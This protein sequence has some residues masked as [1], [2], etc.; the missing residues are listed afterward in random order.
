MSYYAQSGGSVTAKDET[1]YKNMTTIIDNDDNLQFETFPDDEDLTI[2]LE[3]HGN[4]HDELVYAF[5]RSIAPFIKAGNIEYTGED[6]TQWRFRFD[7]NKNEWIEENGST[8]YDMNGFS[9]DELI[10]ELK[11]R[12]YTITKST[13][14]KSE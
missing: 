1:A 4:Y 12:G 10:E 9:D 13:A 3:S 8:I 2:G 14:T 6:G 7:P 5:I 11:N